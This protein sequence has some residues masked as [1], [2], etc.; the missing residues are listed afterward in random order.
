MSQLLPTIIVSLILAG[1]V[2]LAV[3][4]PVAVPQ[5]GR[6]LQWGL[7]AP[8]AGAADTTLAAAPTLRSKICI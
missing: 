4:L 2:A 6:P 3:R 8:A 5:V 7:R 1:V